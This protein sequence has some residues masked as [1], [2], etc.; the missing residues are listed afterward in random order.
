MNLQK[1]QKH[2]RIM[3]HACRWSAHRRWGLD[4]FRCEDQQRKTC[5][6]SLS[7][8]CRCSRPEEGKDLLEL[9]QIQ[10]IECCHMLSL[11][12][13]SQASV[14]AH[15]TL[16]S[17]ACQHQRMQNH[18]VRHLSP[19]IFLCLVNVSTQ[20]IRITLVDDKIRGRQLAWHDHV[21]SLDTDGRSLKT[22]VR[23]VRG[24][25]AVTWRG[26]IHVA[27]PDNV[28][29]G[30]ALMMVMSLLTCILLTCILIGT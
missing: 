5:S 9:L 11:L 18:R 7:L 4:I 12:R 29:W 19:T 1:T 2:R 20:M 8:L 3:K 13:P 17:S 24:E 30:G 15:G 26:R 25:L 27:N 14:I 28:I 21:M 6:T 16:R 22:S 10:T 23:I